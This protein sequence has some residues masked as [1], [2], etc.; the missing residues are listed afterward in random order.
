MI[1][2]SD[3]GL[4]RPLQLFAMNGFT[5]G[6][7]SC[8][9]LPMGYGWPVI[10]DIAPSNAT[11]QSLGVHQSYDQGRFALLLFLVCQHCNHASSFTKD[12]ELLRPLL[13]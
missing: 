3:P 11:L 12:Y 6:E 7:F 5:V 10:Q 1:E 13:P 4:F 2:V 8:Q 9:I